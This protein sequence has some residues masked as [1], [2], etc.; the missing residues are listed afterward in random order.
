MQTIESIQRLDV[1]NILKNSVV[2]FDPVVCESPRLLK[3]PYRETE[4]T[5]QE[6]FKSYD[7]S[8]LDNQSNN[9]QN[10][11]LMFQQSTASIQTGSYHRA[12]A[13]AAAESRLSNYSKI[14]PLRG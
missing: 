5:S 11:N 6:K 10:L 3:K 14:V 7:G 13:N 1:S 4:T 2:S 8:S 9:Y 12:K